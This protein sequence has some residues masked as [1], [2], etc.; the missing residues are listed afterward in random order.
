M[1]TAPSSD[2]ASST[3]NCMPRRDTSAMRA[4]QNIPEIVAHETKAD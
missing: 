3:I 2:A 1:L 4:F